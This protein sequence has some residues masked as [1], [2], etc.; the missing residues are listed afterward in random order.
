LTDYLG[1]GLHV[2]FDGSSFRLYTERENGINEV[3]LDASVLRNFLAFVEQVQLE[4]QQ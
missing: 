4:K 3:F 1:D 2:E